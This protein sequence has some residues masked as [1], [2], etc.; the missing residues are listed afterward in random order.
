MALRLGSWL[1]EGQILLFAGKCRTIYRFSRL[2]VIER[3]HLYICTIYS[4]FTTFYP[5]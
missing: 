5:P 3:D 1:K 2:S 4:H